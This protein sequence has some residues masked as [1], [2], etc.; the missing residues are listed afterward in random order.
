VGGEDQFAVM[1]Q[2]QSLISSA[3]MHATVHQHMLFDASAC[4]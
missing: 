1:S 2:I 3:V 4:V